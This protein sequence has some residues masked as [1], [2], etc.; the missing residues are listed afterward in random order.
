MTPRPRTFTALVAVVGF[1]AVTAIGGGIALTFGLG[2]EEVTLPAAWLDEIP[3]ID[4]WVLPGLVLGIGFGLG[5]ALVAWGLVRRPHL[6]GAAPLERATGRHWS[7]TGALVLGI[8]HAVWIGLEFLWLPGVSWLMIV[9]G[10]VAV[11]IVA[12]ATT[13][14]V[15]AHLANP[16][17][18]T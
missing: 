7:W 14:S 15:R 8:G 1:L 18:G 9:Y 17:L 2:G 16:T 11:T 6:P 13:D 5:S 3:L 10:I 4:S 12:L